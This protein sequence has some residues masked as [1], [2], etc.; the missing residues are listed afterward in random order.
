MYVLDLFSGLK[1]WSAA[2]IDR[3]HE[4]VSV[5]IEGDFMPSLLADVCKL[6][7]DRDE[8]KVRTIISSDFDV[9][10][11]SPPCNHFSVASISKNWSG[12]KEAYIPKTFET[13]QAIYLVQY[14]LQL[15]HD[16][17][18]VFWILENPMGVLRKLSFMQKY[19]HKLVTYCQYGERRM[20]PTDLWGKFPPSFVARRCKN[21]DSCH[22][23]APRGAK[24]GTQG[25]KSAALRAKIPYQLSLEMCL[26]CEDELGCC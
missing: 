19:D 25:I 21:G 10:L 6:Y 11:A 15:I 3:G 2:F 17:N 12:G 20:K 26:A 5:D 1:G 14:T 8:L 7:V 9:V 13:A 4:V 23:R 18:P 24:T 16:I 22:E